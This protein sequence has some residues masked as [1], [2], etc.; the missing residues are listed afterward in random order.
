L[1]NPSVRPPRFAELQHRAPA[2]PVETAGTAALDAVREG[3]RIAH[4]IIARAEA[5]AQDVV[6]AAREQGLEEGRRQALDQVGGEL[7]QAASALAA[8]AARLEEVRR[9]LQQDVAGV[10]PEAAVE[11]ATRVLRQELSQRPEVFVTLIREAIL[12]VTPAPRIEIRVHPD[13]V[14]VIGHHRALLD[15]V[16]RGVDVRFEPSPSIARGGCQLETAALT[17]AA[18]IPE[19]LERA[20]ALLKAAES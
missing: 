5:Q 8:A 14:A 2:E 17:L 7:R 10:L 18:G 9:R 15:D 12:T 19:Q 11:I 16:L 3:H 1:S 4:A 20:L 13:D 6:A